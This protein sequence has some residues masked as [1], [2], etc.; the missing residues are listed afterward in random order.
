MLRMCS[1][2]AVSASA[3]DS[4]CQIGG[5]VGHQD[6][7]NGF[8]LDLADLRERRAALGHLQGDAALQVQERRALALNFSLRRRN[9]SQRR[10]DLLQDLIRRLGFLRGRACAAPRFLQIAKLGQRL[11]QLGGVCGELAQP[12]LG[13][14]LAP[15]PILLQ[16]LQRIET[17]LCCQGLCRCG[18][19][20]VQLFAD[21][22]KRLGDAFNVRVGRCARRQNDE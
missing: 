7:G 16:A 1:G 12:A 3:H 15:L 14:Q 6:A 9:R 22:G 18:Q 17:R 20:P 19:L 21:I 8:L 4:G 5:S 11:L 10:V 13:L 2:N